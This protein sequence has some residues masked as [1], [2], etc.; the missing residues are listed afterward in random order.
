M[1]PA[2]THGIGPNNRRWVPR[3]PT[4]S[5][6][7]TSEFAWFRADRLADDVTPEAVVASRRERR[8]NAALAGL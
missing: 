5:C 4:D 1:A 8:C 6:P 7:T 3:A 2:G